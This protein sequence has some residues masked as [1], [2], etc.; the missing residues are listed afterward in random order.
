LKWG[1]GV[2]TGVTPTP[3]VDTKH[4]KVGVEMGVGVGVNTNFE[5]AHCNSVV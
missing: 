1:S 4:F 2:N 5:V 3:G